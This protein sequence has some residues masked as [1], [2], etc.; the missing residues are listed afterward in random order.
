MYPRLSA[1]LIVSFFVS[2]ASATE[3]TSD[4]IANLSRQMIVASPEKSLEAQA[5]LVKRGYKDVVPAMMLALRFRR[6]DPA[7]RKS[8]AKLTGQTFKTWKVG[9]KRRADGCSHW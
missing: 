6:N 8:L 2:A 4:Q 1:L 5:A 7:V 9:V 3:L